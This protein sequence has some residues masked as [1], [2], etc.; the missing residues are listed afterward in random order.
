ML[1]KLIT[2]QMGNVCILNIVGC[3]TRG[4]KLRKRKTT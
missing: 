4:T 2:Y 3:L 1:R